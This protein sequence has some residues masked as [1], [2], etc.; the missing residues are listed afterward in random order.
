MPKFTITAV[1]TKT[2]EIEVEA[3]DSASA[4]ESLD[5]WIEDD[6]EDYKTDGEWKLEA[7]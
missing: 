3:E 6:F 1:Q 5:E 7:I 4:I 2:Y